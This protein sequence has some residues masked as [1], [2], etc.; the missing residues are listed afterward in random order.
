MFHKNSDLMEMLQQ[1]SAQQM[2][3]KTIL[4]NINN[5]FDTLTNILKLMAES[6]QTMAHMLTDIKK[7]LDAIKSLSANLSTDTSKSDTSKSG[8]RDV[9]AHTNAKGS[10][11]KDNE[12]KGAGV[13]MKL[14]DYLKLLPRSV[15]NKYEGKYFNKYKNKLL[16]CEPNSDEVD[17]IAKRMFYEIIT[18]DGLIDEV[19]K[20]VKPATK[21]EEELIRSIIHFEAQ[22]YTDFDEDDKDSGIQIRIHKAPNKKKSDKPKIL[23]NPGDADD[24]NKVFDLE[25]S[26]I[27]ELPLAKLLFNDDLLKEDE[28]GF[29]T[30][31]IGDTTIRGMVVDSDEKFRHMMDII[32]S[33]GTGEDVDK[34][35]DALNGIGFFDK[36]NGDDDDDNDAETSQDEGN[37]ESEDN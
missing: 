23:N 29:V 12:P 28:D 31:K 30:K 35:L 22:F 7:S 27:N 20:Y 25:S 15:Y 21:D 9:K 33:S 4:E 24:D 18:D 17:N 32:K 34:V 19:I 16:R 14:D 2:T 5:S 1:V 10:D 26:I 8:K 3:L 37:A 36:D 13:I 6:D 11:E